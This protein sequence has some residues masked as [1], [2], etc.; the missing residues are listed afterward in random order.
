MRSHHESTGPLLPRVALLAAASFAALTCA[1]PSA[2]IAPAALVNATPLTP[3]SWYA[4]A[5][6]GMERC[7]G[8]VG[9][10]ARIRWYHVPGSLVHAPDA[11]GYAAAV[12]YPSLHTIVIADFYASD[13]LVVRHEVMHDLADVTSHPVEW[14]DGKCGDLLP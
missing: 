8:L 3:P 4:T 12:T 1:S 5:Y 6:A 13:T 7:S 10:Y 14:F 9:D 2:P 11:G